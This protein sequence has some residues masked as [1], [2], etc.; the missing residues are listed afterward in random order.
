MFSKQPS[1]FRPILQNVVLITFITLILLELVARLVWWNQGLLGTLFGKEL[2]LL[3]EPIVSQQQVDILENWAVD[4]ERYIQYDPVL[5]WSIRPNASAE[6]A[7]AS[8]TANSAGIRSLREYSLEKPAG[9]LRIGTFGP[10]F[11]HGDEVSDGDTWQAQMEQ[12]RPELEV[13]NWGVGGYGT[14]QAFLRYQTQGAAYQPH[15]VI[16]GF[17]E[18]NIRRN[19]N[20]FRPFFRRRTGTPLTK[21]VFVDDDAQGFV[22]LDNPFDT[23]EKLQNIILQDPDGFLDLVCEGDFYC[24]RD[25]YQPKTLDI[26]Y[27]YRFLRT[28]LYEVN[29]TNLPQIPTSENKYVQRV[30]FLLLKKFVAEIIKN[31]SLPIIL[32][33]PERSSMEAHEGGQPTSYETALIILEDQGL[34]VIDLAP[35]FV[36]AKTTENAAYGDYYATEGGHYNALGNYIVAQTVLSYLCQQEILKE[37]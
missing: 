19:V 23:V 30:N 2:V 31:G 11:T 18:D 9:V 5:G 1:T 13:M 37:C 25:R 33:F 10:S 7:G 26:F 35:A 28:L 16:I 29:H 8:Y 32:I 36:H 15:I 3:P 24:N 12:T 6:Q 20:R 21:P 14:D 4:L 27:S 17:E 34:P 22:L